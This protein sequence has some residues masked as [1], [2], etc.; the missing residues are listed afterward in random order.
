MQELMKE[1]EMQYKS[2]KVLNLKADCERVNETL[3]EINKITR[4]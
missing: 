4:R 3:C 1:H 2:S